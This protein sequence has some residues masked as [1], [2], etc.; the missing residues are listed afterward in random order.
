MRI[1]AFIAFRAVPDFEEHDIFAR[2]V[3]KLMCDPLRGKPCAH[4]RRKRRFPDIRDKRRLASQDKYELILRAVSVQQ[5]GFTAW[6][7][8]RKVHAKVLQPEEIAERT[9]LA[10]GHAGK[11]RFRIV[12]WL[13]SGRCSLG[14]DGYRP[15]RSGISHCR[16]HL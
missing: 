3:Y 15:A 1:R 11:E 4:A 12:G 16:R 2:A 13:R 5:R 6:G 9:L 7:K 14:G 10:P 8:L